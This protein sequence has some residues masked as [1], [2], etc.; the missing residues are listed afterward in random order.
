VLFLPTGRAE[1]YKAKQA[2][3]SFFV[4]AGDV[5]SALLIYAGT[6]WLALDT[7]GF[8]RVNLLLALGWLALAFVV[9]RAYT[10][11]AG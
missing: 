2:I 9:G 8:A 1:K 5:L 7:S 10:R 11:R 6:A 3:D 4:R